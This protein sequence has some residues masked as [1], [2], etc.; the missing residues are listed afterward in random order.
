MSSPFLA[1]RNRNTPESKYCSCIVKETAS[2]YNRGYQANPYAVC[3]SSVFNRR[4]LKGPGMT[5]CDY[6]PGYIEDLK[7]STLEGFAKAKGLI[8]RSEKVSR[9]KLIKVI[10]DYLTQEGSLVRT[11][12]RHRQS[13]TKELSIPGQDGLGCKDRKE[14]GI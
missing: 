3:T 1:G 12:R 8:G 2:W 5:F 7:M 13:G 9:D 4:G 6:T 14:C 10:E 11:K